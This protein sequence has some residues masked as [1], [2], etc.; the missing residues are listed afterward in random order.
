MPRASVTVVTATIPER[1][2]LLAEVLRSVYS[3]TVEVA[4]H[5]VMAQSCSDGLPPP[6]HC[7]IQQNQLL[8]AVGTE[9]TMRLADDDRLL[10]HHIA[11][12]DLARWDPGV[13]VVYSFDASHNRP[14][15]N[16]NLWDRRQ[17]HEQLARRNWIDGSA[18]AIR[19]KALKEMDGWPTRV[20]GSP[21]FSGWFVGCGGPNVTCEDW[22]CFYHLAKHG[23]GFACVPEETWVY[24]AGS[25][26]RISTGS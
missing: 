1:E 7:A 22:A 19:T 26:P 15:E 21:P 9:W 14:H 2:Y 18:V 4:A 11:T 20:H 23:W 16:C 10:P 17:L 8:A 13:A 12:L 3:Q 25:W 24:G 5:L 6:V